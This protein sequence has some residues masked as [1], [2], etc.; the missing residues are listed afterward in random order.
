MPA[1]A[2]APRSADDWTGRLSS[3]GYCIIP[4]LLPQDEIAALNVA[5]D[6]DF[7]QTPFSIG[8][9]FGARTKRF[10]RLL[11][12]APA[13]RRLAE[14]PTVLG[15][16]ENILGPS[17]DHIQLNLMQAIE[18][19]PGEPAQ[20]PHRDQ[21][22]YP[23]EKG[24]MEY[25]VNVMWPLGAFYEDNGATRIWPGTHGAAAATELPGGAGIAAC[26]EPGDT[27]V[28]LGSV[29]HGGG[30][31]RTATPRRGIVVGYSLGWLKPYE[32]PWLAYPPEIARQFPESLQALIGYRQHRPN[33]NNYEG[34]CPSVLLRGGAPGPLA[35][36]DALTPEQA[37]MITAYARRAASENATAQ[38]ASDSAA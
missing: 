34:Q 30:A 18:I 17:C 19:H 14:H 12:R 35:A 4:G 25:L 11:V 3:Q 13:A 26:C 8:G 27:I 5:L 21:D 1:P 32:N 28:F 38:A 37:E 29:L 33:L 23:C 10:G 2:L 9:F 15:V 7:A 20:M 24:R 36:V 16:V 22:M 6:P 31:N